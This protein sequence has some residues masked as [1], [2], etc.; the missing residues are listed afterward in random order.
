MLHSWFLQDIVITNT[1]THRS[2]LFECNDWLSLDHGLRKTK[3]HI[4]PTRQT[5]KYAHTDY[6]IIT[7]TGDKLGAGTDANV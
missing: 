7:I 1:R 6:E 4:M 2:W 3:I 5:D